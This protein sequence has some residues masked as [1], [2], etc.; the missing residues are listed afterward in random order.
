MQFEHQSPGDAITVRARR[1]HRLEP[2]PE[3]HFINQNRPLQPRPGRNEWWRSIA[4]AI[5]VVAA[6]VVDGFASCAVAIHPEWLQPPSERT[7]YPPPA[8]KSS[9]GQRADARSSAKP[10]ATLWSRMLRKLRTR[11]AIAELAAL[12]DRMLKDIG[13]SRHEIKHVL[14]HRPGR[15]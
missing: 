1:A 7:E 5:S 11:H 2:R 14:G 13:I 6:H 4:A 12:D 9:P 15:L 8:E 10:S 3:I